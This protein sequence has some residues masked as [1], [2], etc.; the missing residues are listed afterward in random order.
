[1]K[2]F[3][4]LLLMVVF[5]PVIYA[6]TYYETAL[7]AANKGEFQ[8]AIS[9]YKRALN[10]ALK[11]GDTD[12]VLRVYADY[13]SCYT[14]MGKID[15]TEWVL[16][17]AIGFAEQEENLDMF[18]ILKIALAE[19]KFIQQKNTD[20]GEIYAEIL[21]NKL[22]PADQKA[23][24][25]I[26][27]AG[28][29]SRAA[30]SST[31]FYHI[32]EGLKLAEQINDSLKLGALYAAKATS[33]LTF[34]NAYK[35]IE[36]YQRSIPYF[37]WANNPLRLSGINRNIAYIFRKVG[38][39]QKAIEFCLQSLEIS[40]KNNYRK[41]TADAQTLL[42]QLFLKKNDYHKSKNYFLEALVYYNDTQKSNQICR[43]NALLAGMSC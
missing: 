27:L 21:A 36:Y 24:A 25:H 20:A 14:A 17:Q 30:D 22:T 19:I 3:N 15:S 11:A 39:T 12:K 2:A 37:E 13:Q 16:N 10:D 18:F 31:T 33:E 28:L 41:S 40:K 43:V 32:E 1:M 29:A 23:S 42:G 9:L 35:A 6:Q 4:S 8:R 26:R 34:G 5:I 38:N 7:D